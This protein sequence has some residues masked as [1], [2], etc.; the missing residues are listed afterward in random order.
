MSNAHE[1]RL[2]VESLN[3]EQ[4][5]EEAKQLKEYL[6][7]NL[8][9]IPK[10]GIT[11][12]ACERKCY[13]TR[14]VCPHCKY[15]LKPKLRRAKKRPRPEPPA[16]PTLEDDDCRRCGN[17]I[18]PAAKKILKCGCPYHEECLRIK[19]N[20]DIPYLRK[21]LCGKPGNEIPPEYFHS[22]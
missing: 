15:R 10:S 5:S 19:A 14:R 13:N 18:E 8:P 4:I 6:L 21:C 16:A 7:A 2:Y 1:I 12:P 9:K 17:R 3:D 20:L 11:C 22:N